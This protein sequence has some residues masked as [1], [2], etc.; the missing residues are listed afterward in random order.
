MLAS[1]STGSIEIDSLYC[2][3]RLK[4]GNL[5]F[6]NSKVGSNSPKSLTNW[7]ARFSVEVSSSLPIA[8]SIS[9]SISASAS[10][11]IFS[12]LGISVF[13]R[14]SDSF[15]TFKAISSYLFDTSECLEIVGFKFSNESSTTDFSFLSVFRIS[16]VE[17]S[18]SLSL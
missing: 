4:V 16:F 17:V 1:N 8:T 7:F 13:T 14:G 2:F 11:P 18:F 12:S 10:V 15:S 3:K 6:P 5:K 9:T